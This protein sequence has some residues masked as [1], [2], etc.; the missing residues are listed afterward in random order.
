MPVKLDYDLKKQLG[1]SEAGVV[2]LGDHLHIPGRRR[3]IRYAPERA[4]EAEKAFFKVWCES[5]FP[6]AK[7]FDNASAA[8]YL[9]LQHFARIDGISAEGEQTYMVLEWVGA[10]SHS[11]E[12]SGALSHRLSSG[13]EFSLE[14]AS[15]IAVDILNALEFLHGK[16]LIHG[17]LKSGNVLWTPDG[18]VKLTDLGGNPPEQPIRGVS[19]AYI[20]PEQ[21][22][23]NLLKGEPLDGRADL[24]SFS[25]ILYELLTGR[26]AP[27]VLTAAVMPSKLNAKIPEAI[28]DII[29][30]GLEMD[31][32]RRFRDAAEMRAMIQQA[33][34]MP[35][36]VGIAAASSAPQQQAVS[37]LPSESSAPATEAESASEVVKDPTNGV[38]EVAEPVSAERQPGDIRINPVDNAVMVWVPGGTLQMGSELDESESPVHEVPVKGFWIYKYPITQE[39]FGKA[40]KAFRESGGALN[41]P[42]QWKMGD[43]N[44]QRAVA[45]IQWA[46]AQKYCQWAG[47]RLPTEAEW[48]WAA[49][50]PEGRTYPWGEEWD[51]SK[52]NT[53]DGGLGE[54]S[55]VGN[56]KG[57]SWC[58]AEDMAGNVFEWCSSLWKPYP[59]DPADGREDP[60]APGYRVLRGGSARAKPDYARSTYRGKLDSI[61][62][63]SG[64][65]PVMNDKEI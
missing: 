2:A 31:R 18:I 61:T 60:N 42:S 16:K 53:T 57:R 65:R 21:Q 10:L 43:A 12:N 59:Y 7:L 50:G 35:N 26:R 30:R 25:L 40:M 5:L 54:Q 52:A 28:D 15:K 62:S 27:R 49:R 36:T 39:Q 17:N 46:D 41:R 8:D 23:S 55:D 3:V 47:V 63:L 51:P 13:E 6:L 20:S 1:K 64:F 24:F 19:V 58:G 45:G 29:L 38:V 22:D 9:S 32:S 44:A 48:E 14:R 11:D 56:E 4:S 37:F 34:G 33:F